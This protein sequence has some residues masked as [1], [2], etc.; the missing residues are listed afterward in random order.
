MRAEGVVRLRHT[1]S[2]ADISPSLPHLQACADDRH[3]SRLAVPQLRLKPRPLLLPEHVL[4]APV[5]AVR[6][7]RVAVVEQEEAHAAGRDA[8]APDAPGEGA[9]RAAGRVERLAKKVPEEKLGHLQ[10]L[11]GEEASDGA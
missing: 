8:E 9:L 5:A 6:V 2:I 4:R 11:P 3:L 10:A 1:C 7:S